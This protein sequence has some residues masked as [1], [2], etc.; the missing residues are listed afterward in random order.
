MCLVC[1]QRVNNSNLIAEPLM[2]TFFQAPGDLLA[3]SI[4]FSP[5]SPKSTGKHC[6]QL[7]HIS[8][9]LGPGIFTEVHFA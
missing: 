7:I 6:L 5:H 4:P 3:L 1:I 9:L 8:H 2:D